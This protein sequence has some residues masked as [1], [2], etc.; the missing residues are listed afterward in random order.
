MGRPHPLVVQLASERKRR[1]LSAKAAAESAGLERHVLAF[2]ESGKHAS[3]RVSTLDAL[4]GA[5]GYEIALINARDRKRCQACS[6]T[7]RCRDFPR[8][9]RTSDERATYCYACKAEGAVPA[10]QT[11][12]GMANVHRIAARNERA[13]TYFGWRDAGLDEKQAAVRLSEEFNL[14]A[15]TAMRYEQRYQNQR[16]QEAA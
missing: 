15:R 7:K 6:E 1:G 4:A 10:Q 8:D 3:P 11:G 14:G 12:C 5:L 2:L 13:K 9:G 16:Q